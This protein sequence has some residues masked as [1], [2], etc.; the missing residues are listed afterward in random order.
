[1]KVKKTK[2][3]ELTH[4]KAIPCFRV[5]RFPRFKKAD[6]DSWL[7]ETYTPDGNGMQN[8]LKGGVAK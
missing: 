1:M 2:I 3:Y 5:G 8:P 6:I 4:L 7:Q